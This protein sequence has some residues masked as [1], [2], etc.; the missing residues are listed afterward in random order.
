VGQERCYFIRIRDIIKIGHSASINSRIKSYENNFPWPIE[1]LGVTEGTRETEAELLR[2]FAQHRYERKREWFNPHPEIFE[3]IAA[4]CTTLREDNLRPHKISDEDFHERRGGGS[5]IRGDAR[6]RLKDRQEMIS[7]RV[8]EVLA[9]G[10]LTAKT[11]YERMREHGVLPGDAHEVCERMNVQIIRDPPR[12]GY[13]TVEFAL[14]RR[15]S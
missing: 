4:N 3:F 7:T 5:H 13:D 9:N 10:P 15:A 12:L 14:R 6:L 2:R 8:R 1:V 11:F